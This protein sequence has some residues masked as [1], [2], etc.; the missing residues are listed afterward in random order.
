MILQRLTTAIR[1]QN[2][3]QIITEI[4]IVVIGIFLGLQ[5]QAWYEDRAERVQ[6][7]AHDHVIGRPRHGAAHLVPLQVEE[8]ARVARQQEERRTD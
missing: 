1:H 7:E 6:E 3:S 8:A 2:W 4:L 5:V